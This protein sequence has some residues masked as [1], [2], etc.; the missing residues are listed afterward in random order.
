MPRS[1]RH[2]R[3]LSSCFSDSRAAIT[4]SSRGRSVALGGARIPLSTLACSGVGSACGNHAAASGAPLWILQVRPGSQIRQRLDYDTSSSAQGSAR[5]GLEWICG[6][7]MPGGPSVPGLSVAGVRSARR[8]PRAG[9]PSGSPFG[10]R[11][12]APAGGRACSPSAAGA[13]CVPAATW[14]PRASSHGALE[15]AGADA[16]DAA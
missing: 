2:V 4:A 12:G 11:R 7:A 13:R 10:A 8:R 16:A 1:P 14:F 3:R 9:L 15:R 6:A 5:E